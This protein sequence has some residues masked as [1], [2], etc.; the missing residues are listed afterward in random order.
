MAGRIRNFG[1]M[2]N[3]VLFNT[4]VSWVLIIALYNP[5]GYSFSHWVWATV[6]GPA[7]ASLWPQLTET[8]Q[9]GIMAIAAIG[10]VLA[11][12]ILVRH[13]RG[14]KG[15]FVL[16]FLG[17]AAAFIALGISPVQ[18]LIGVIVVSGVVYSALL[19]PR[20]LG[21]WGVLIVVAIA[22]A[23]LWQLTVAGWFDPTNVNAM[24]WFGIIVLGILFGLAST[25]GTIMRWWQ[26]RMAVEDVD[27]HEAIAEHDATVADHHH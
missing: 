17:A 7:F 14:A 21:M 26:D 12:Y 25:S 5:T 1:S 19:V 20:Y 23:I 3:K 18:A 22:A 2:L 11:A 6:L 15:L 10:A 9:Y 16:L 4:V 24:Q 13:P 8:Q 27:T